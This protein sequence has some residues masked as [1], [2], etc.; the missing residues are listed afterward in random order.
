[1]ASKVPLIAPLAD[2]NYNDW[3]LR[4]RALCALHGCMDALS[5]GVGGVVAPANGDIPAVVVTAEQST[6]AMS[7]I[8]LNVNER[9]LR[10]IQDSRDAHDAWILLRDFHHAALRPMLVSL[11][12][13]VFSSSMKPNQSID[14]FM[15]Y[16]ECLQRDLLTFGQALPD[17]VFITAILRALTPPLRAATVHLATD[18]SRLD[19]VTLR[20]ALHAIEAMQVPHQRAMRVQG[21]QRPRGRRAGGAFTGNCHHCGQAGHRKFDCYLWRAANPAV[22]SPAPGTT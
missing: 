8:F 6:K 17:D 21:D 19:T 12:D 7:I 15:D 22:N 3:A 18:V 11:H 10:K 2:A 16:M 14:D 13:K 4:I 9:W 1:M 20:A 5:V